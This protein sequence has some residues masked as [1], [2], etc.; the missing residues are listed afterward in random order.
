MFFFYL[1]M[2]LTVKASDLSLERYAPQLFSEISA[3]ATEKGTQK[4]IDDIHTLIAV[5]DHEIVIAKGNLTNAHNDYLAAYAIW[6]KA[7]DEEQVALT[8]QR[9]AENAQKKAEKAVADAEAFLARRQREKKTADGRVPPA[10]EFMEK[11][12]ARVEAEHKTL[13]K[14]KSILEKI[15][16]SS[17]IELPSNERKLL[18]KTTSLLANPMF[19]ETLRKANPTAVNQVITLVVSLI[20]QGTAEVEH[21]TKEY[22][23]RVSEAA[24]AAKNLSDAEVA[25]AK[26][27]DELVSAIAHRKEMTKIAEAKSAVEVAK[28]AIRD[29]LETR[30]LVQ[31]AFTERELARLSKEKKILLEGIRVEKL[32]KDVVIAI[33]E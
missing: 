17:F 20:D 32:L 11:E 14:V 16:S 23:D 2:A 3:E 22:N 4:N 31:K 10:K 25:L 30:W 9:N 15:I 7:F 1:I 5:S 28:R 26:R 13:Y 33:Q 18:S 21:A 27:R 8:N 24:T 19:L 29:R 6:Q 12:I